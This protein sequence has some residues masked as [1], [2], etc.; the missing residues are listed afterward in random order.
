MNTYTANC[1]PHFLVMM[2]VVPIIYMQQWTFELGLECSKD[3]R[4]GALKLRGIIHTEENCE[5]LPSE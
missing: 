3:G 2:L 5:I 1:L 4:R